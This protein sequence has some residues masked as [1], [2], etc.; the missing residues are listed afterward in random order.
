MSLLI[1]VEILLQLESL[2]SPT[3]TSHDQQIQPAIAEEHAEYQGTRK[4]PLMNPRLSSLPISVLTQW[5]TTPSRLPQQRCLSPSDRRLVSLIAIIDTG[6]DLN[7]RALKR[8]LWE[9]PGESGLDALGNDRSSNG[10]DDDGNG[11]ID[12]VHGWNFVS[13]SNDLR[14]RHGH[15]THIAGIIAAPAATGRLNDNTCPSPVRLMILKY[16]DP[17]DTNGFNLR[18]TIQAIRYATRMGAQ[19]I[20]YSA[21]GFAPNRL[22]E[23]AIREAGKRGVLLIAAAGN[24]GLNVDSRGFFP[25]SYDLPNVLSVTAMGADNELLGGS[26]F[27]ERNV[28]IAAPGQD[29]WSSLPGNRF[30]LMSGTSQAT[31][32]VT[33]LA[34][35]TITMN[36]ERPDPARL[37]DELLRRG[38]KDRRLAGKT[39]YQVRLRETP[40]RT[41]SKAKDDS[42][43]FSVSEP[44]GGPN[45]LTP[46]PL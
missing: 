13:N 17:F 32:V 39:R 9:N 29:I 36:K 40:V 41:G 22:E 15:G 10:L 20:N 7:H 24:D 30:G 4:L 43:A 3:N 23:S 44:T 11:Y 25:A 14:D 12:D 16:F 35:H 38:I 5:S 19:I 28:D 27:G 46:P 34:A 42:L 31:A 37:R 33:R 6:V 2:A 26:N 8:H 21:G 45:Q 18:N 1:L